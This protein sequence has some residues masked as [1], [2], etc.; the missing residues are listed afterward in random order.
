MKYKLPL[1]VV[2]FLRP[3]EPFYQFPLHG[4]VKKFMKWQRGGSGGE[5][6]AL[7]HSLIV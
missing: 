7:V 3:K 1:N 2:V 4:V 5:V 6:R